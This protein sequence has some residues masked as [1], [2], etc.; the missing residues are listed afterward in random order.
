FDEWLELPEGDAL[1]DEAGGGG[2]RRGPSAA[3]DQGELAHEVPGAEG[4]LVDAADGDFGRPLVD[5][6]ERGPA[7]A[8][9]HDRLALGEAALLEQ[10]RDGLAFVRCELREER[11]ALEGR[12]RLA[13]PGRGLRILVLAGGDG[14]ALE[15]VERVA[16]ERPLDVPPG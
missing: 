2:D 15:Q 5:Q 1:A 7:R 3:V 13:R 11:G 14:A 16:V 4:R 12:G 6:E 8:L 9:H 10:A